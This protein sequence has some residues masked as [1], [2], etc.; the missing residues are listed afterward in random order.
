VAAAGVP[1]TEASNWYGS[2]LKDPTGKLYGQ[3][4]L[5]AAQK[6]EGQVT[7]ITYRA[8]NP[9]TTA[10]EFQKVSF[11]STVGDLICGAAITIGP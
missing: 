6:P 4:E 3:E 8:P 1:P 7:E 10:P 5:A 9:G 2:S 11:I